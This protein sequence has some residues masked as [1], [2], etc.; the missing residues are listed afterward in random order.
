MRAYQ[1]E[2]SYSITEITCDKCGGQVSW[3]ED[4]V[5]MEISNLDVPQRMRIDL[6]TDC[7]SWCLGLL[8]EQGLD[9]QND[10][11]IDSAGRSTLFT[12]GSPTCLMR[13]EGD[14]R[15]VPPGA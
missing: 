4:P 7:K 13:R 10:S 9:I 11:I 3:L 6:C 8:E 14:M 2:K 15:P 1:S 5:Y 12:R